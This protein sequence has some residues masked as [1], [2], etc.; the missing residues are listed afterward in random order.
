MKKPCHNRMEP[1]LRCVWKKICRNYYL[2]YYRGVDVLHNDN[3]TSTF[4]HLFPHFE[5]ILQ[6]NNG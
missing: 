6:H 4:F 5:H 2:I 3:A 1:I